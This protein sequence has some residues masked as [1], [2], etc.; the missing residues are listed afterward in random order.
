MTAISRRVS[1]LGLLGAL[2]LTAAGPALADDATVVRL[3][4]KGNRFEPAEARVP[5]GKPVVKPS[6]PAFE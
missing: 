3:T 2:A 5:A 6:L 4:L 1:V